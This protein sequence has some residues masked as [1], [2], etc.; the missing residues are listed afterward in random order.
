MKVKTEMASL[1]LYWIE[2]GNHLSISIPISVSSSISIWS[3]K[4]KMR[5]LISYAISEN[6]ISSNYCLGFLF[7][8][9]DSRD[10][11]NSFE[12]S[13]SA[14]ESFS[15]LQTTKC[16]ICDFPINRIV[17]HFHHE[18]NDS[19]SYHGSPAS[20]ECGVE[21]IHQWNDPQ[22]LIAV[23]RWNC[24]SF[25]LSPHRQHGLQCYCKSA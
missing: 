14:Y 6:R 15:K 10:A 22:W 4:I 7:S 25:G 19:D 13:M 24:W 5:I 20:A 12:R 11:L 3:R 9:T 18:M 17:N 1:I 2:I 16:L 8:L 21:L 23:W